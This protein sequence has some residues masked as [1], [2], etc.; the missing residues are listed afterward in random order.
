MAKNKAW[1]DS[2][3]L[4][5]H[6]KALGQTSVYLS[7][8]DGI[9]E[10]DRPWSFVTEVSPGGTHRCQFPMNSPLGRIEMTLAGHG[11]VLGPMIEAPVSQ[12]RGG[13]WAVFSV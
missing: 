4:A 6:Y 5:K 2:V 9:G 13:C 8:G 11:F 3:N 10:E 7:E 1:R 12:Y